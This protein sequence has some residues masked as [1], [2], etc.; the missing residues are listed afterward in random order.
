LLSL[1]QKRTVT[2]R[3]ILDAMSRR[4]CD[5]SDVDPLALEQFAGLLSRQMALPPENEDP[6]MLEKGFLKYMYDSFPEDDITDRL[7]KAV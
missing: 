7:I 1:A 4:R 5:I 6:A 3:D 2:S